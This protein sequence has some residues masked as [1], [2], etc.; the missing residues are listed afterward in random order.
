ML[1]KSSWCHSPPPP[2]PRDFLC[3]GSEGSRGLSCSVVW[4]EVNCR[5]GFTQL[6]SEVIL[7]WLALSTHNLFYS[8]KFELKLMRVV[9]LGWEGTFEMATPYPSLDLSVL[10]KPELEYL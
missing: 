9:N 3:L 6:Y 2:L 10:N 1:T 7:N 8:G 4:I 5:E